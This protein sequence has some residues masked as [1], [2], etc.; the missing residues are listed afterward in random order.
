MI[1]AA[2]SLTSPS[3]GVHSVVVFTS[4][5]NANPNALDHADAFVNKQH[6][7]FKKQADFGDQRKVYLGVCSSKDA[8]VCIKVAFFGFVEEVVKRALEEH[9]TA[10]NVFDKSPF[11]HLSA[12]ERAD[13]IRKFR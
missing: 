12:E 7:A 11:S 1:H 5:K 2:L 8:H 9:R 10:Q 6:L 4:F 3:D 13:Q